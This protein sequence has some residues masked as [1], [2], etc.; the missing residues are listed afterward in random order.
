MYSLKRFP[1]SVK[2]AKYIADYWHF[3]SAAAEAA[4]IRVFPDSYFSVIFDLNSPENTFITGTM[5]RS[6]K[7]L[8][9][10]GSRLFGVQL[11]P[12]LVPC[13]L[14]DSAAGFVNCVLPAD[15]IRGRVGEICGKLKNCR[16]EDEMAAAAESL[17]LPVLEHAG[18]E[19]N[20]FRRV[21]E[22]M[23]KGSAPATVR[24]TAFLA[25]IS[26]KQLERYFMFHTGLGVKEFGLLTAFERSCR[27]LENGSSSTLCAHSLRFYDQP[28]FIKN[29][30]RFSG[31]TPTEY[32]NV[33]FLQYSS[34]T[35]GYD[36]AVR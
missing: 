13:L 24:E 27:M 8:I 6:V 2:S 32:L 9:D 30:R 17:L 12:F 21:S 31:M 3:R 22:A 15:F 20:V 36:S 5:N 34:R 10:G 18:V 33:G 23:L 19:N 26:E 28:H 14:K 4:E 29:F 7:N 25:G 16:T 1:P 35:S 11:R